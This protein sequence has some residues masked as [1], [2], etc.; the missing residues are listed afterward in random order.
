MTSPSASLNR[1]TVTATGGSMSGL[2][3]KVGMRDW[4]RYFSRSFCRVSKSPN[5]ALA[6]ALSDLPSIMAC[7]YFLNW[8]A[9]DFSKVR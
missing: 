4:L 6:A 9:R 5:A 3:L 7:T 2:S 1:V 8:P